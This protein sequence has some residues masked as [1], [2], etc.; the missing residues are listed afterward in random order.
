[1][2]AVYPDHE[3]TVVRDRARIA[4]EVYERADAPTLLLTQT[5]QA[6]HS[7]HWKFMI[8][9]LSR[10]YRVVTYD[11]VGNGKSDRIFDRERYGDR[12]Q[13]DDA[14]A[15]LDA[16]ET[17]TAVAVGLSRG[18]GI[19]TMLGAFHP[20]RIDGVVAIAPTH[21]WTIPH[22]Y[23]AASYAAVFDH[24]EN[25][26]GW[27]KYNVHYWREN[28][29]DFVEFFFAECCSDPHSTKLWDDTTGW[30]METEG[31]LIALGV[32]GVPQIRYAD[33][34][35][36]VTAMRMPVLIIH[37]TDDHIVSYESSLEL[38]KRIPHAQLLTMDGVGHLPNGRYPVRINHAIKSFADQTYGRAGTTLA[39]VTKHTGHGGRQKA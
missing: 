1:M 18:G 35:S 3:A 8:P 36:A 7:R 11:P 39:P 5:W 23:R 15:V 4:F 31:E 14:L 20:D 29:A 16:T 13:L 34:E 28:W 27:A 19:A 21:P 32:E 25:P 9:Y 6:L 33:I 10:H 17:A 24:V 12:S 22:P 2:R 30:A 37:G 26:Q 38:R